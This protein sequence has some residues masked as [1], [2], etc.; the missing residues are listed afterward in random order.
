[1]YENT[2]FPRTTPTSP[3][4]SSGARRSNFRTALATAGSTPWS[5]TVPRTLATRR[6]PRQLP[7][8]RKTHP[9]QRRPTTSA[10]CSPATS[11]AGQLLTPSSRGF[12]SAFFIKNKILYIYFLSNFNYSKSFYFIL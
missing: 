10:A 9:R 6:W 11:L 8:S 12:R 5:R 4:R 2:Q 3:A 7:L 1:M